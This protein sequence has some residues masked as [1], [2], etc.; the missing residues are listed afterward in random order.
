MT[1]F[2]DGE[3]RDQVHRLVVKFFQK[4]QSRSGD[5]NQ[6]GARAPGSIVSD[7]EAAEQRKRGVL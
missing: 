5:R 6:P 4:D 7:R 1:G 3:T 2:A